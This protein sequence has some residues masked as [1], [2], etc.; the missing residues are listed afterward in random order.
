MAGNCTKWQAMKDKGRQWQAMAGDGM[1]MHRFEFWSRSSSN[2][3]VFGKLV[4]HWTRHPSSNQGELQKRRSKLSLANFFWFLNVDELFSIFS[5][6]SPLQLA[7]GSIHHFWA[8]LFFKRVIR[9]AC[10]QWWYKAESITVSINCRELP[11]SH[12]E[13]EVCDSTHMRS[14]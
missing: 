12:L 2:Q 6:R 13:I 14:T 10:Q 1:F 4:N 11:C 7:E 8:I 3:K 5:T 9:V